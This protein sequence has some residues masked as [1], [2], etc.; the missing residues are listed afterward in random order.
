MI[1]YFRLLTL[2][3][4]YRHLLRTL[5]ASFGIIFGVAVIFAVGTTKQSAVLAVTRMIQNTSGRSNLIIIR[6]DSS[7][8]GLPENLVQRVAN[9]PG[10]QA[11]VPSLQVQTILTDSVPSSE[12]S[13]SFFGANPEGG[14]ILFAVDMHQDTIIRDYSLVQGRLL[15]WDQNTAEIVLVKDFAVDNRVELGEW[16]SI[17]TP[18]GV[19]SLKVVGLIEKEGPGQTNNGAFGLIPLK[20]GQEMFNS[21]GELDVIDIIAVD[22]DLKAL[23]NLKERVQSR[24]GQEYTVIY[25]SSPGRQMPMILSSSQTGMNFMSGMALFV[26]AFLIYNAFSLAVLEQTTEFGLLR[27]IGMTRRQVIGLVLG[28]AA[29]LGLIA[30]GLGIGLGLLFSQGL[31]RIMEVILGYSLRLSEVPPA[32]LITRML[33]SILVGVITTLLAALL[34]AMQAGRISALESFSIKAVS[35]DNWFIRNGWWLGILLLLAAGLMFWN[36]FPF[37]VQFRLGSLTVFISFVGGMFI[38]PVIVSLGERLMRPVF[39]LI[40]GSSGNLGS[41]NIQRSRQRTTLT[42]AAIMVGVSMTLAVRGMTE[43]IK[44]DLVEWLNAYWGG[45]LYASSSVN[46][47]WEV[48]RRLEVVDGVGAVVPIRYFEVGWRQA[49]ETDDSITFMAVDPL[50]YRQVTDFVFNDS[51]IDR[52]AAIQRLVDGEAVFVSSVISKRYDLDQGDLVRLKTV[53][54]WHDFEIAAV[55]VD[56]YNQGM[57]VTGSYADMRRFFKIEDASTWLLKVEDAEEIETVKQRIDDLYGKRYHLSLISNHSIKSGIDDLMGQIFSIFDTMAII[58]IVVVSLGVV[59]ALTMNV[60]ER[61]REI[62]MLRSIGMT[63]RQIALMVLAEAGLMG[64]VGAVLGLV[65]GYLLVRIFLITMMAMF[66]YSPTLTMPLAEVVVTFLVAVLISQLAALFPA[67]RAA[68]M[69]VLEA[70]RYE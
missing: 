52:Q 55:V 1:R 14:L 25:P 36:P 68:R 38:I 18:T 40:Y 33:A 58:A 43:S 8:V 47:P 6:S 10:V 19:Q 59:N 23:E 69:P 54:G 42:V 22:P 28:E 45:D 31:S 24:V 5:L 34:P 57:V 35:Q 9:L 48:W 56:F 63:R 37:D 61:I 17:L 30:S 20:L 65:F 51:Q 70:V 44:I 39:R 29:L 62:G 67:L 46:L 4:F 11:A 13:V 66:G 15:D 32:L 53:S 49:G 50:A 26:G 60:M 16:I 41:R 12:F 2:R 21:A 27:T 64:L 3:S 7:E